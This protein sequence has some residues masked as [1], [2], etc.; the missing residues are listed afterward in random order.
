MTRDCELCTASV[1]VGRK[2]RRRGTRSL[3]R[4][5]SRAMRVKKTMIA[6]RMNAIAA[7][8]PH[9]LLLNEALNERNA[10]V[11]VVFNG[12]PFERRNRYH[13][14]LGLRFLLDLHAQHRQLL[15][16][17]RAQDAREIIH[18]AL[19]LE[20]LYLFGSRSGNAQQQ[21]EKQS[22]DEFRKLEWR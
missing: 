19:R 5:A 17:L 22:R 9:S 6:K 1:V 16:A 14:N 11:K 12:L 10:G 15:L 8:T 20:V 3:L 7:P 4:V 18:V 13:R 2:R 21:E